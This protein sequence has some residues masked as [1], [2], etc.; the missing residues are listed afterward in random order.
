MFISLVATAEKLPKKRLSITYIVVG[1]N[2]WTSGYT[3]SVEG[4]AC[5]TTAGPASAFPWVTQQRKWSSN[6]ADDA[7]LADIN[8]A[9]RGF[10]L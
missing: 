8:L 2:Y 3:V 1:R 4:V 9:A 6:I 10:A 5:E 7:R